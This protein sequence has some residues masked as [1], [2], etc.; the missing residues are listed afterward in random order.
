MQIHISH[1]NPKQTADCLILPVYQDKQ[2]AFITTEFNKN[3]NN[4]ITELLNNKELTGKFG[5]I[6]WLYNISPS[7]KNI[8]AVGVGDP[9]KLTSLNYINLI[10]TALDKLNDYSLNTV[11]NGLVDIDFPTEYLSTEQKPLVWKL[12]Q[13]ILITES[14]KTTIKTYQKKPLP[15]LNIESYYLCYSDKTSDNTQALNNP[16][17]LIKTNQI[18]SQAIKTTKDLANTPPNIC[19][20]KYL[21]QQAI[22]LSKKYASL[23]LDVFDH[24]ELVKMGMGSFCSVSHGS[25]NPGRLIVFEYNKSKE[26]NSRPYVLI[27]KGITFD[28]GGYSLKP[29][30]SMVGMKYDM[31]GS[32]SVLATMQAVCELNL[33]IHVVG[34]MACAENM[35]SNNS[36]RPD[37]IVTSLSGK[38]IE[39]NN[40]DAEGR[41]VLCDAMTYSEKFNPKVVIDIATLTGAV[42]VA[43][44]YHY[45]GLYYN[46]QNLGQALQNA[47]T[48]CFDPI[49]PMPL[50]Q[51]YDSLMKSSIADLKNASSVP[52]A[53]SVTAACFLANFIPNDCAWA[54]LDIAGSATVRGEHKEA[55]GRPV[56]LLINYLIN[57]AG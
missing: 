47:A 20:P 23:K 11:I 21:E 33:P 8:I 56:Q 14:L 7:I 31:S 24:D 46:D 18:I 2:Q 40:T 49:W 6:K 12:S 50:C 29:P 9:E 37:D 30:S 34:I 26:S 4:V 32:A 15:C 17:N 1:Y 52:V 38:T 41:L 54:H 19:N 45:S 22:E 13:A 10:N 57:E 39:I 43:L 55:T 27:G 42:V 16:E 35:I 44:G 25:G 48:Q 53:G 51:D 5:E 3:H 36:T 28:T